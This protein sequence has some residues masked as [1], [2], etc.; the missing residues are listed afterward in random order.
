MTSKTTPGQSGLGNNGN[1]GLLKS[2]HQMKFIVILTTPLFERDILST[3]ATER[4]TRH[5]TSLKTQDNVPWFINFSFFGYPAS[6]CCCRNRV[7]TA[8]VQLHSPSDWYYWERYKPYRKSTDLHTKKWIN[9][10]QKL[11][12]KA[13]IF[14]SVFSHLLTNQRLRTSFETT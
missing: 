7:R 2:H 1:E 10:V 9:L 5:D 4:I 11:A 14:I 6:L 12:R 8:I 13:V 3:S